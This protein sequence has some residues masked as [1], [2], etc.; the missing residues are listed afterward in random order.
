VELQR[1]AGVADAGR[2]LQIFWGFKM[3][4]GCRQGFGI[5]PSCSEPMQRQDPFAA[6]AGHLRINLRKHDLGCVDGSF[7]HVNAG[8]Q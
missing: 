8:S 3:R 2:D 1:G 6:G 7:S 5:T 4:C